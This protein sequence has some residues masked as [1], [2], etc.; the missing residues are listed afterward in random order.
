MGFSLANVFLMTIFQGQVDLRQPLSIIKNASKV[1]S[2][3][4]YLYDMT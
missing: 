1:T 3:I 2:A 4:S